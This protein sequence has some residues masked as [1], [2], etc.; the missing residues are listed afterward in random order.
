MEVYSRRHWPSRHV[1]EQLSKVITTLVGNISIVEDKP[2]SIVCSP[3][4]WTQMI[5]C[6]WM[7]MIDRDKYFYKRRPRITSSAL[8]SFHT[9]YS[10]KLTYFPR[11]QKIPHIKPFKIEKAIVLL[12]LSS[13]SFVN[14]SLCWMEFFEYFS[15]NSFIYFSKKYCVTGRQCR[16]MCNWDLGNYF[17]L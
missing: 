10:Y 14:G 6:L 5:L 15:F 8:K 13:F 4:C 11:S 7:N 12:L 17:F 2:G 9:V 1:S 16:Y 3:N